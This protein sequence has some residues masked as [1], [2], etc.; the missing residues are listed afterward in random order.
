MTDC[1]HRFDP[2]EVGFPMGGGV[3][4]YFCAMCQKKL[5]SRPL[6]DDPRALQKLAELLAAFR[7]E[8]EDE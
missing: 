5:F 1:K 2:N 6:D 4:D 3:V 7:E 8:D